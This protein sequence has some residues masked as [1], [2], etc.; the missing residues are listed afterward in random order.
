MNLVITDGAKRWVDSQKFVTGE[1]YVMLEDLDKFMTYGGYIATAEGNEWVM[2]WNKPGEQRHGEIA[3]FIGET[4]VYDADGELSWIGIN[5][6]MT[7]D[8][9]ESL[10]DDLYGDNAKTCA[11]SQQAQKRMIT[12]EPL[13]SLF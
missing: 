13:M 4:G 3:F 12:A 6:F 9:C 8:E 5:Q 2:R 7:P 1:E 10:F 11:T